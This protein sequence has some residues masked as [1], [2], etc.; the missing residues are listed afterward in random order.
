MNRAMILWLAVLG[1]LFGLMAWTLS[2]V[3][4]IEQ[5]AVT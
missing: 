2:Q 3:E 4:W 1:L 5:E